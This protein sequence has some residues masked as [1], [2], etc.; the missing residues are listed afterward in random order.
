MEFKDFK[1][2]HVE[3][4]DTDEVLH[5]KDSEVLCV[6]PKLDGTNCIVAYE[7]GNII[8]G[9]RNRFITPEN[10]NNG[11]AKYIF[12]NLYDKL[13]T[14]FKDNPNNVLYGEYLINRVFKVKP[15]YL[16]RFYIFDVYD[17]VT[18][19]YRQP[20]ITGAE[21]NAGLDMVPTLPVV[22]NKPNFK[23]Y[24]LSDLKD[25]SKFLMEDG[26]ETG[27]GFVIKD[28][29]NPRNKYGRICWAKVLNE[30]P[31]FGGKHIAGKDFWFS[32]R[33]KLREKFFTD[34]F[35]EKETIKYLENNNLTEIDNFNKYANIVIAEFIKEEIAN[36]V[37]KFK[38]PKI[39]FQELKV[40]LTK[41]L[42]EKYDTKYTKWFNK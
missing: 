29:S 3:H 37:F 2:M 32:L 34:A 35:I 38:Y 7:D 19:K 23:E 1:Y 36:I 18:H 20:N 5:L 30:K 22:N 40:F 13:L 33:E 25:F 27:E 39:N 17:R 26:F 6:Q 24:V 4:W 28:Y 21:E 31:K 15:E 12:N 42:R 16:N 41:I 11:A 8:V 10:D 9:S 14:Y